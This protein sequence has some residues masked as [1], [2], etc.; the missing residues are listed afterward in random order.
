ME[1]MLTPAHIAGLVAALG[2]E[3]IFV[4]PV[5]VETEKGGETY[6]SYSGN[7][8]TCDLARVEM[9]PV[10]TLD[11]NLVEQDVTIST[12]NETV[13]V[14]SYF[15]NGSGPSFRDENGVEFCAIDHQN[16]VVRWFRK[17][18][19]NVEFTTPRG[20]RRRETDRRIND[21]VAEVNSLKPAESKVW[22]I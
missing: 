15:N 8:V 20:E 21:L 18:Q 1:H 9:M 3:E 4:S 12:A 19:R 6:V 14:T 13:K 22:D 16:G 10:I 5:L 7:R 17:D 2:A 11:I